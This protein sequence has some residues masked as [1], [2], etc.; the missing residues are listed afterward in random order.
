VYAIPWLTV[1]GLLAP[2][3]LLAVT[4][5]LTFRS[6]ATAG[7]YDLPFSS[8]LDL[9]PGNYWLG[10]ISGP[11]PDVAA[12]AYDAVPGI[13]AG[14]ANAYAAGPSDP[15]GPI[16]TDSAQMSVYLVYDVARP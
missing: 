12:F 5:E 7:W 14:N 10:L 8:P 6:S 15:F 11:Q 13:R 3:A 9:S 16:L 2:G 1:L 4:D